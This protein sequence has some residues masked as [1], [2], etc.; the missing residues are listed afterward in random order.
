MPWKLLTVVFALFVLLN[1]EYI[2]VEKDSQ[3]VVAVLRP[4]EGRWCKVDVLDTQHNLIDRHPKV[5]CSERKWFGGHQTGIMWQGYGR[6]TGHQYRT[7]RWRK[8]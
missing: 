4:D 2:G 8:D 3:S 6:I 7:F 5:L 1:V